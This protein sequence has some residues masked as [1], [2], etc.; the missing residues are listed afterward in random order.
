MSASAPGPTDDHWY[1]PVGGSV[2]A[3]GQ[4]VDSESARK[5][6]AWYRG[7]DI[8]ATSVA[9]LP[10]QVFER[11]PNDDGAE[12][13]REHPLYDILHD[14]PNTYQDSFTWKRQG[15]YH[16][17]D[18]GNH[19]A[20]IVSGGRGFADQLR[21]IV[22]PRTVTPELLPSWN[23]VF[24]VRQKNGTTRTH[25]EDEI[26]HL[27]G[28]S[29]DGI[30]GKGVLQYARESLGLGQATESYA[31]RLFSQGVLHGGFVTVPGSMTDEN[32]RR[33][34]ASFVTSQKNWHI[35]QLLEQ[36]ATFTESKI[37]PEDSQMLES[38]QYT[39]DDIAR[40][41]GVPRMMLENSDPNHGNADQFSLDFAKF[42]LGGWLSM[43]EFACNRQ[44]ILNPRRFYVEFVRDALE[45]ADLATRSEANVAVVNAGI[46]TVN[47][48]RRRENRKRIPGEADKLRIPENI[49][50]KPK[51][52]VE[53]KKKAVPVEDDD[54]AKAQAILI[55]AAERVI[56]K[57]T[58]AVSAYAV[59]H[60]GNSEAFA[61]A[62][63]DFYAKHVELVSQA[64]LMPESEAKAYCANQAAQVLGDGG[65]RAMEQWTER[66]YA[67]GLVAWALE[68]EQAA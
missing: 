48:V 21:P 57:E 6:S 36:G 28:P 5:L 54:P 22:D 47:E 37:T 18:H 51:P 43:W 16:I 59:K 33:M 29:D 58:K 14:A 42:N 32:K 63:T 64:L 45:R 17:I 15:G 34:A 25:G 7:R 68:P 49:T 39:I 38:R 2:T 35:P 65:I 27:M 4:R 62:V 46:E 53:P 41:L 50:G 23:K 9:M 3:S 13:A 44:L 52:E 12:V 55:N 31:Q 1:Y 19:Y 40:W 67:A 24:H 20:Y 60:A 66:A 10:L 11:L 26:F 61:V 56:R 30:V 8:L